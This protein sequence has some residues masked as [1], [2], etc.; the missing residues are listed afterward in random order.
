MTEELRK[1]SIDL[2]LIGIGM[3]AH[4]AFNYPPADFNN[5]EAYVVIDLDENCKKQQVGEG[6]FP[7]VMM[8]PIMYPIKLYL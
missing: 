8:Y 1:E 5:K 4:I 6:W 7:T 2:G 3:N